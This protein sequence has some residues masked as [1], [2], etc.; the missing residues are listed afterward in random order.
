MSIEAKL[1][2][3]IAQRELREL[4][5]RLDGSAKIASNACVLVSTENRE[6]IEDHMRTAVKRAEGVL[7]DLQTL[8]GRLKLVERWSV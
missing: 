5:D 8:V 7:G 1:N 6:A 2:A 3:R 4:A